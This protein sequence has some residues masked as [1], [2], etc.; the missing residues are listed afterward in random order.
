MGHTQSLIKNLDANFSP[1]GTTASYL[2][3]YAASGGAQVVL[4]ARSNN[5]TNYAGLALRSEFS[6][7]FLVHRTPNG[8][9]SFRIG[10]GYVLVNMDT[11]GYTGSEYVMTMDGSGKIGRTPNT[12]QH[13]FKYE[14]NAETLPAGITSSLQGSNINISATGSYDFSLTFR[15]QNGNTPRFGW[16]YSLSF[17]NNFWFWKYYQLWAPSYLDFTSFSIQ[18]NI[19]PSQTDILEISGHLVIT[20]TGSLTLLGRDS[21][22]GTY[23]QFY[24]RFTK[25]D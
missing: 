18:N 2:N 14:P 15:V 10:D 11:F 3:L 22:T 24:F 4:D 23:S 13:F 21:L 17:S 7:S 12:P 6:E 5:N 16:T 9:S 19:Q 8:I 25:L 1:L 20:A